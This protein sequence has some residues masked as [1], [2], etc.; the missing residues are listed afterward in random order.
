M[1]TNELNFKIKSQDKVKSG[2]FLLSALALLIII[3]LVST[4]FYY[5]Y[6]Q[7]T[8][9]QKEIIFSELKK[10]ATILSSIIDLDSYEKMLNS[11][12]TGEGRKYQ[13]IVTPLR[14]A[15]FSIDGLRY[16]YTVYVSN[17]NGKDKILFGLDTSLLK[18]LDNDGIIDHSDFRSE[19]NDAPKEILKAM[20]SGQTVFTEK[21]YKDKYG[22]FISAFVPLVNKDGK[23]FS[24]L[25]VDML[26]TKYQETLED[27]KGLIFKIYLTCIFLLL[28]FSIILYF[29]YY[30]IS[31]YKIQEV[32][33]KNEIKDQQN[34]FIQDYKMAEIG[35]MMAGITHEINNPL[36]IIKG[37]SEQGMKRLDRGQIEIEAHRKN[38]ESIKQSTDRIIEIIRNMKSIV[39]RPIGTD[40]FFYFSANESM[41]NVLK[42]IKYK[43]VSEKVNF[44][45][46]IDEGLLIFGNR[47]QLEQ[48]FFNMLSNS[49]D[50]ISSQPH[51]WVSIEVK[52]DDQNFFSF[53]FTDSGTD[54]TSEM[55]K[56][57]EQGYYTS[58]T[59]GSGSGMGLLICKKILLI[60][61]GNLTLQ[62]DKNTHFILKLPKN[63]LV[64]KEKIGA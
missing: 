56:K 37:F 30:K 51:P 40:D 23:V 43:A 27:Y 45:I 52:Q 39:S 19:Y 8:L 12:I 64:L 13:E 63:E 55:Y 57:I 34:F 53:H 33:L 6:T 5:L 1:K 22:T 38:Y 59:D 35:K 36:S 46:K 25:G 28:I 10:K 18:D 54:L 17:I 58:K 24:V 32:S 31:Q 7:V 16:V 60:H 61:E 44:T 29:L 15:H 3:T 4:I 11:G 41:K 21:P 2:L 14:R 49:V 48:V 42:A 20:K 26:Y 50:A 9:N 47:S 62:P